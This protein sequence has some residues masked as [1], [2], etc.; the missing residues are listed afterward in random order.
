MKESV[1]AIIRWV[2]TIAGT[3]LVS[4]GVIDPDTLATATGAVIA[5]VGA[6][7]TLVPIVWSVI[8]KIRAAKE[9]N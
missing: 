8:A 4:R 6:L 3:L 7:A 1:A 2:S 5:L 9:T